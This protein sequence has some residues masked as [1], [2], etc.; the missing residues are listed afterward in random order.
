MK[1][2]Y[3]AATCCETDGPTNGGMKVCTDSLATPAKLVTGITIQD[4]NSGQTFQPVPDFETCGI[5]H[6][7]FKLVRGQFNRN[8]V[9]VSHV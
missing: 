1:P 7:E 4:G 5:H 8:Q 2:V 6:F 9:L 3:V